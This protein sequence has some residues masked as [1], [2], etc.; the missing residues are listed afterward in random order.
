MH[1]RA[2]ASI[3]TLIEDTKATCSDVKTG[4]HTQTH[5]NIHTDLFM[6]KC[7]YAH[8]H[9]LSRQLEDTEATCSA[10][11][12]KPTYSDRNA[13]TCAYAHTQIYTRI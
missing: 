10:Q 9:T 3:H 6:H 12:L 7:T 2:H 8:A 4:R 1:K 11:I 5:T 13:H